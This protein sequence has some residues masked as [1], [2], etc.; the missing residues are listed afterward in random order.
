M[1]DWMGDWTDRMG[2]RPE[3]LRAFVPMQPALAAYITAWEDD[4]QKGANIATE[5][6]RQLRTAEARIEALEKER[7]LWK[8]AALAQA[9]ALGAARV[10]DDADW[11]TTPVFVKAAQAL[12][13]ALVEE[14]P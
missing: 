14:K 6:A 9:K 2:P 5:L 13:A 10:L 1:N 8:D 4:I 12:D 3:G 11:A 7:D